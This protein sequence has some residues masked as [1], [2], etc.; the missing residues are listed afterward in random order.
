MKDKTE[1][2]YL[3]YNDLNQVEAKIKEYTD[4]VSA[5]TEIPSFVP[6]TWV[7]NELPYVQEIDRIEKGIYNLG[8]YYN[9]PKGWLPTKN[10]IT[11]DNPYPVKGFDYRDWNR[12]VN[13]LRIFVTDI[14]LT[15]TIWNGASFYEWEG[16]TNWIN[17]KILYKDEQVQYENEDLEFYYLD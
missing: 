13:N 7:L 2:D 11:P 4:E 9:R 15:D 12:W 1:I 16:H 14:D 10:W 6:K 5:V 3:N 8:E 17:N